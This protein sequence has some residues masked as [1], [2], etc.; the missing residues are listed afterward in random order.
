MFVAGAIVWEGMFSRVRGDVTCDQASHTYTCFQ[1]QR[2]R[3][4]EDGYDRALLRCLQVRN[5]FCRLQCT[6]A[7]VNKL[8]QF[9]LRSRSC[10]LW[11]RISFLECQLFT[12]NL[13][14]CT[15]IVE[16]SGFACRKMHTLLPPGHC[17]GETASALHIS[18]QANRPHTG[19]RAI[20][21]DNQLC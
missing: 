15:A 2:Y 16:S 10:Q 14:I 17:A 19:T 20:R 8:C 21:P 13:I 7:A 18:Y 12:F 1:S 3:R 5:F 4:Q 11:S 9:R 6:P